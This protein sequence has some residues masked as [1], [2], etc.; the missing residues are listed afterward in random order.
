M[1]LIGALIPTRNHNLPTP[2][3]ERIVP[4]SDCLNVVHVAKDVLPPIQQLTSSHPGMNHQLS[5][6]QTG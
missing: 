4:I 6:L 3:L 5:L 2:V 1:T